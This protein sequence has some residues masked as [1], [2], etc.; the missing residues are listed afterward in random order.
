MAKYR[1]IFRLWECRQIIR[2]EFGNNSGQKLVISKRE[3]LTSKQKL[4]RRTIDTRV[5]F[6]RFVL[7]AMQFYLFTIEYFIFQFKYN[8]TNILHCYCIAIL[9]SPSRNLRK[10][11]FDT[12]FRLFLSHLNYWCMCNSFIFYHL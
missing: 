6:R 8:D 4:S 7:Y 12:I 5:V 1:N 11:C 9:T 2:M 3:C 10:T